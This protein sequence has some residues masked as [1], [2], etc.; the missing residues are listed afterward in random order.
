MR[1]QL[2]GNTMTLLTRRSLAGLAVVP[3]LAEAAHAV[4]PAA[5]PLRI[6][7]LGGT[8]FVGPAIVEAA[9][10][11]GHEVTLFNRGQTQPW[12]F[13]GLTRLRG[14]RFPERGEGLNAL[15]SG[16]WDVAIDLPAYYPRHVTASADLLKDRVGRYVVMSSISVYANYRTPGIDETYDT[17]VLAAPVAE[18]PE[19]LEDSIPSYGALKV[20]CER[21]VMERYGER[22]TVLRASGIAGG[23][24]SDPTK[25]YWLA[26][27]KRD[28]V[29][30]APGEGS[31]AVQLVDRRDVADFTLKAAE[32]GLGGIYNLVGPRTTTREILETSQKIV[33]STTRIVWQGTDRDNVV[34]GV[35]YYAPEF[36]VPGFAAISS[37]KARAKGFTHR[38]LEDTLSEDWLWFR[39]N[40]PLSFDFAALNI[41]YSAEAEAAGIAE[42]G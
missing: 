32:D 39:Q 35:P 6:L 33:G 37:E 7:V 1:A 25:W 4:T 38:A 36:L 21:A 18:G 10:A 30:L 2:L 23:G 9:L 5:K 15:K 26:R 41:G 34:R 29:V 20:Q 13:P 40:H 28:R 24:M 17:K 31:D 8:R 19:L 3:M 16:T 42:A 22:A 27:M 11:R 12:L 14:D